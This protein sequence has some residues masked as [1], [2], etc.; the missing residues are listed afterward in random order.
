MKYWGAIIR[1]EASCALLQDSFWW[2]YLK[3]FKKENLNLERDAF[4]YFC[5]LADSFTA[6]FLSIDSSL[7]DRFFG[8]RQ[9]SAEL[10]LF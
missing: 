5:R 10:D 4:K 2:F 1:S 9:T 6:L 7:R 8:V 3:Y